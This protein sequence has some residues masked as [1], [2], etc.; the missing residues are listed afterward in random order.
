MS[1]GIWLFRKRCIKADSA[2]DANNKTPDTVERFDNIQYGLDEKYQLLDV[3][4]PKGMNGMLP[5]I[6]SVHG[7]GWVY[8]DKDV[9]Q[10]YCMSLARRGFIV[11]NFTY[12]LAPKH[13]HPAQLEDTNL[14]FEWLLAHAA[15]YSIDTDKI[16]AVGDSA[17]A[18]ILGLYTAILTNS[19]YA[20]QYNLKV[21]ENLH[22]RALGL[23][24][25]IYN[26]HE[27]GKQSF[28]KAFLEKQGTN[29]ELDQ[30]SLLLHITRDFPPCFIM[31]S[32]KDYL[33]NEAPALVETLEKYEIPHEYKVYG[34]ENNPLYHVFHCDVNS[35]DAKIANNAECAFFMKIL[36]QSV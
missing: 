9:Y 24:C 30:M 15:Q 22:I 26:M 8:G 34:A 23:N 28:L 35:R 27:G 12:R 5:V 36:N 16:F 25:G 31:T 21:P 3:Y 10:Y 6:V 17:G 19:Q 32:V 2:R 4:R 7:G 18:T 14:V 20:K 1:I 13:K 29:E 33:K 11:V